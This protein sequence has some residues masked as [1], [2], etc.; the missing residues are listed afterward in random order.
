LTLR[1][2]ALKAC[3]IDGR[4]IRE[5][6]VFEAFFP[7]H[8]PPWARPLPTGAAA[9]GGEPEAGAGLVVKG[10]ITG[11]GFDEIEF[12]TLE[13]LDGLEKRPRLNPRHSKLFRGAKK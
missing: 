5:G 3:V 13:D 8:P 12:R 11:P 2:K 9:A 1:F 7:G 10:Y 6:E 4:Y